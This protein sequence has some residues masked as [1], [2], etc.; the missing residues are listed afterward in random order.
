MSRS[1]TNP[2]RVVSDPAG[3]LM[4]EKLARKVEMTAILEML[5]ELRV[6]RADLERWDRLSQGITCVLGCSPWREPLG[7]E[8]LACELIYPNEHQEI[9]L[10]EILKTASQLPSTW[11]RCSSYR[12]Y[13]LLTSS[14]IQHLF[15][16]L[17]E[18]RG[19]RTALKGDVWVADRFM[20]VCTTLIKRAARSRKTAE[21]HFREGDASKR[22]GWSEYIICDPDLSGILKSYWETRFHSTKL[23]LQDIPV[24]QIH[25]GVWVLSAELLHWTLTCGFISVLEVVRAD[26]C[27]S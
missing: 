9:L 14:Q 22:F 12:P 4:L 16:R 18:Q 26:A 13:G 7:L 19:V 2:S 8:R 6:A 5:T 21:R 10:N 17:L 11:T 20:H 24:I 3:F 27:D 1:Y 23:W 15:D 25:D